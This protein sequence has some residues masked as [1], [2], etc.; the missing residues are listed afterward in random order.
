MSAFGNPTRLE[1]MR[2]SKPAK[3]NYFKYPT[4]YHIT[5]TCYGS[6]LHGNKAGSTHHSNTTYG[7]PRINADPCWEYRERVLMKQRPYSLDKVRRKI[8]LKAIRDVCIYRGWELIALHIRSTHLH[9]VVSAGADPERVMRDFK[10]YASRALNDAGIDSKDRK[11]WTRHGSTRYLWKIE[12]VV[13]V[14]NYV[15]YKQGEPMEV[16]LRE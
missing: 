9:V 3:P 7:A 10:K 4:A 6:H 13:D 11:R 2:N 1:Y 5:F 16:Y 14:I 15:V 8:V 12:E